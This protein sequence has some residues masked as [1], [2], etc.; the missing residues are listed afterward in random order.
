M[1]TAKSKRLV[2]ILNIATLIFYLREVQLF[3]IQEL[4]YLKFKTNS[5]LRP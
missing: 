2:K 4:N 5:Y 1:S 3:K